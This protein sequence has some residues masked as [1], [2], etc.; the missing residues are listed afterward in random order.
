MSD[1]SDHGK[2]AMAY[3]PFIDQAGRERWTTERLWGAIREAHANSDVP[4]PMATVRG[5][6]ELRSYAGRIRET[7]AAL[8]RADPA[9]TLDRRF[10]AEAPWAR[11]LA[12]RNASPLYQVRFQH[13]VVREGVE[14][15][16]W[17]TSMIYGHDFPSTVGELNDALELDAAEMA[18]SYGVTHA[19]ISGAQ[20]MAV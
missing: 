15:T 19:G 20:V 14:T 8:D 1:L 4:L 11:D 2:R 18:A 7:S 10:M 16:E 6:S 12:E 3:W 13:T 9:H 17:R 5:V